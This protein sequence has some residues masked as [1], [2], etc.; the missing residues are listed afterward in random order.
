[1]KTFVDGRLNNFRLTQFIVDDMN[2][3]SLNSEVNSVSIA[4]PENRF[5]RTPG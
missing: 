2:A 4:S 5:P 1:M 3:L